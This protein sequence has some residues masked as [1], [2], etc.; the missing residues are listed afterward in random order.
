MLTLFVTHVLTQEYIP[1]GMSKEKWA[2]IKKKEAEANKGKNL[3][4]IGITKFKS[5]SF[6]SWQKGG[7]QHLFPVDPSTPLTERP[8]MQR[9]GGSADGADLKAKGLKGIGQAQAV[10]RSAIDAKYERLEKEGKLR[11]T[12]FDTP[13][14]QKQLNEMNEKK[15]KE[16]LEMNAKYKDL[17]MKEKNKTASKAAAAPEEARAKP[18][19]FGL[20]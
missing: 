14:T 19:L 16:I 9:S 7:Q 20:F 10:E 5:R 17:E 11:S 18:K 12:T 13:W 6:E 1:D 2:E 3:G 4:A 15:K 8:Y